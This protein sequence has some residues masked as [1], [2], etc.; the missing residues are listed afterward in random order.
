MIGRIV[1]NI[2]NMLNKSR[3]AAGNEF[4]EV[5]GCARAGVVASSRPVP[6]LELLGVFVSRLAEKRTNIILFICIYIII[7]L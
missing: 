6:T 2:N 7:S 3:L 4:R 5:S 1:Q